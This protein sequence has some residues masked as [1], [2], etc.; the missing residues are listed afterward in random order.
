VRAGAGLAAAA[1]PDVLERLSGRRP[2]VSAQERGLYA[3][4]AFTLRYDASRVDG[5]DVLDGCPVPAPDAA[6]ARDYLRGPV[7]VVS[8][9]G[10]GGEHP[11]FL[12]PREPTARLRKTR[13]AATHGS[14]PMRRRARRTCRR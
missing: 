5:E 8:A 10:A 14:R 11:E 6:L 2:Y 7:D 9:V 3:R 13:R 12:L 4:F 1:T